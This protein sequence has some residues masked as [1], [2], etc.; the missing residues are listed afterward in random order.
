MSECERVTCEHE[1]INLR[2]ELAVPRA[3]GPHPAVLVVHTAFGLGE[4]MRGVIRSLATEGYVALAVDMFGEGAYSE[5]TTV[6]AELVRPVWGNS[7]RLRER[8]AAWLSL[9]QARDEVQADRIAAIGYCFGGQCVLEFARGGADI[10]AVISYHGILSTSAPARP[11][12]VRAHV[13]IYT[14]ARDPHAPRSDVDALRSELTAAGA[15]WQITEFGNAYHAFTD[16][17]A[18]SPQQGRAYDRLAHELSWAG[19]LALFDQKLRRD[20]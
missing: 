10:R 14:G 4:Q 11:G 5:D 20:Q 2:G 19:T 6:V 13:G 12:A 1:G 3:T 18:A 16:P 7:S 15:D 17:K 8:M 9:L